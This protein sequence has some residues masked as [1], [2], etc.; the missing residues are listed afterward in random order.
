LKESP[1]CEQPGIFLVKKG[2]K[3]FFSAF[4]VG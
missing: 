2:K 4:S 3:L 1:T